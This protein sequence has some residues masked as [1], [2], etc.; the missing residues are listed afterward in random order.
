MELQT[1]TVLTRSE[2]GKGPSG[3]SRVEG[4]VPGVVYGAGKDNVNILVGSKELE[5][6]LH[7]GHGERAMVELSCTDDPDLNGPAMIKAV[8]HHPVRGNALHFD[9]MRI[10]L[11]KKIVTFVQLKMEG[12]S[13]GVIAGGILDH[14]IREVEVECLP[15]DVPEFFIG[16]VT[17]LDIGDS[18]RVSDLVQVENVTILTDSAR[19]VA[20]VHQPRVIEEE[21][22]E[23]EAV[24]E[25]GED[26]EIAADEDS[27]VTENE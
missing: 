17:E 24:D 21:V 18:L 27:S 9:L 5:S 22:S 19:T 14:N 20:A 26:S 12:R 23:D 11:S 1:F 8:Q 10:D 15:M 4:N 7:Q 16:D 6:L 2:N 13:V 25:A 3:R